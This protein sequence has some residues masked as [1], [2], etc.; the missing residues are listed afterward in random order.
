[1]ATTVDIS[2]DSLIHNVGFEKV[3]SLDAFVSAPSTGAAS[4][5]VTPMYG[6]SG[7][8]GQG[9]TDSDISYIT[10]TNASGTVCYIYPNSGGDGI[11][12]STSRP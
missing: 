1:M 11:T 6:L 7:G 2:L 10:L 5:Y 8:S 4:N 9:T 12:V 3:L